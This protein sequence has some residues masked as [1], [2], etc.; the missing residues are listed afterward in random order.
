MSV[1]SDS[2]ILYLS[3]KMTHTLLENL[4]S[5]IINDKRTIAIAVRNE[6]A[7]IRIKGKELEETPGVINEITEVLNSRDININ[8]IFTII[9]SI[10]IFVD[11]KNNEITI[12]LIKETIE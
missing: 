3:S 1:N 7:F 10:L 12:R 9:S 8:G 4:H 2:L 5:I 11:I 6:L